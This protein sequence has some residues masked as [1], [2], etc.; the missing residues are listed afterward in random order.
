M[1]LAIYNYP[2]YS[3]FKGKM[4]GM[5]KTKPNYKDLKQFQILT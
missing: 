4:L 5:Y 1:L 3:V 2:L